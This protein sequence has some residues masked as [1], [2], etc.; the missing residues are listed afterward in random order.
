MSGRRGEVWFVTPD[1]VVVG[2]EL[3]KDRPC[4]VLQPPEMDWLRTTIVAPLTS[5][6]FQAPFRVPTKFGTSKYVLLDHLRAIDRA[7]LRRHAGD[8]DPTEL[9][10]VLE[11]LQAMFA[12]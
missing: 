2:S 5:R 9:A 4:L 11:T 10:A 3:Q 12:P 1:P 6:G 8:L 7:R